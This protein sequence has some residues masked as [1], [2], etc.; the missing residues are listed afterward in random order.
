M[1][2][3]WKN[4]VCMLAGLWLWISPFVLHYKLG[5]DASGDATITGIFIG[6]LAM[7]AVAVPRAWEEW[8]KLALGL[9]LLVSPWLLGFTN[10]PVSRDNIMAV[11]LLVVALSFWSLVSRM[12]PPRQ[13]A[14]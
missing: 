14:G 9:W 10:Q 3:A 13:L 8:S 4:M 1:K 6:A 7:L 11:G 2:D 12:E 5:S